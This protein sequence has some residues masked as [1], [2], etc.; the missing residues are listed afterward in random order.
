MSMVARRPVKLAACGLPAGTIS[1]ES[2]FRVWCG[3][4]ECYEWLAWVTG[5][6][7]FDLAG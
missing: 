3:V 6:E 7:L 2:L 4:C 5:D 1:S